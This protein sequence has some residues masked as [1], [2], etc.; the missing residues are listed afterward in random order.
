MDDDTDLIHPAE[1][2]EAALARIALQASA[3]DPVAVEVAARLD[4]LIAEL[5][6]A[7][8]E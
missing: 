4:S 2:L 7:L 8:D 5:R 1:R 3:P 6:S